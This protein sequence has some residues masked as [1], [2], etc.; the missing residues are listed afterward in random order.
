[1]KKYIHKLIARDNLSR[2][3]S[4][5]L[6]ALMEN[7]P[8]EQQAAILAL[9]RAKNETIE[10]LLGARDFFFAQ[11]IQIK[12]PYDIVDIVGTG[13]DGIG[14]FNISTAASLVIA[15]CDVYVAK[16]GGKSAT[17]KSGSADVIEALGIHNM[18]VSKSLA[19]N[20]YAYLRGSLFNTALKQYAPLRKN[21]SFPTIFNI[22]GP[23]MNPTSPKKQVIGVY[24]KDLVIKV[25]EILKSLGS[26]HA[27]IV[28]SE[29]GLDEFSIS[30]PNHIAELKNGN[31][32]EYIVSPIDVGLPISSLS[33]VLGGNML[34]NAQIIKDILL[35][36]IIGPKLDIVLLN[37]AAGLLV[38][39]AALNFQEAIEIAREA[40]SSGKTAALLTQLQNEESL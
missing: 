18:D 31:I 3:E 14:T 36:K 22:L 9:L 10:E 29:D 2:L 16:H 38:A 37:S 35:G 20:H 32:S 19:S 11:T 5:D 28:H 40:I 12:A 21:L 8:V 33:E 30:A 7:A 1:M 34:E 39:G 23:L 15:S 17:S 4:Y 25:A 26:Q 13:G 24:R 27:L 6:F